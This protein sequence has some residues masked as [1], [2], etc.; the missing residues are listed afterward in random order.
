[1]T[2][3]FGLQRQLD[4]LAEKCG[5]SC[6]KEIRD[7]RDALRVACREVVAHIK[8]PIAVRGGPYYPY[9]PERGVG[10]CECPQCQW[11]AQRQTAR[12]ATDSNQ[13]CRE[14]MDDVRKDTK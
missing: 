8:Q 3:D 13:L 5:D 2:T 14:M 6:A 7:L 9:C 12:L 4:A 10:P 11:A 1:M